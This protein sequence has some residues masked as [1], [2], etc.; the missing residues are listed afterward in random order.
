MYIQV[1]SKKNMR[2]IVLKKIFFVIQ[3][4]CFREKNILICFATAP[5]ICQYKTTEQYYI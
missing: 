2:N 5:E 4:L 3:E 1:I